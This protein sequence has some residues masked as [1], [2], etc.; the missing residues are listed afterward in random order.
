M[1][2][3]G[4]QREVRG[5][6]AAHVGMY[7]SRV[8]LLGRN[9]VG[10]PRTDTPSYVVVV[11]L[12]IFLVGY[13][14]EIHDLIVITTASHVLPPLCA[15]LGPPRPFGALH[16]HLRPP[17]WRRFRVTQQEICLNVTLCS[18]CITN[19]MNIWG[20]MEVLLRRMPDKNVLAWCGFGR[21][22]G[23]SRHLAFCLSC[24]FR[25]LWR[26]LRQFHLPV[27]L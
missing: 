7:P 2:R 22:S 15:C 11:C 9:F 23:C 4:S 10:T 3:C 5:L 26:P 20:I 12:P 19:R 17:K 24:Q 8:Q 13:V 18:V 21:F 16:C 1:L 6:A 14:Y 25:A 27:L